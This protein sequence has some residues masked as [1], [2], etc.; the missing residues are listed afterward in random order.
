MHTER[1]VVTLH[2]QSSDAP[3]RTI[4]VNLLSEAGK[5]WIQPEGYGDKTSMEG[6]GYPI[7]LEIWQ[8]RLRLIVFD[9][10]HCEDPKIIDLER[11]RERSRNESDHGPEPCSN[12]QGLTISL[13]PTESGSLPLY[14]VVYVIDVN[15]AD[16]QAAAQEAHVVMSDPN[17]WPPILDTMDCLGHLVRIDLCNP[18][19]SQAVVAEKLSHRLWQCPRCRQ[20]AE[21]SYDDLAIVGTPLCSDCDC[22]MELL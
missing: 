18:D 10:I 8:G 19:K 7:A 20:S 17:S 22:E 15:A 9:D 14:R 5:L 11:A 6:S 16:T 13:P 2:E 12:D 3:K 4:K 1:L 21:V